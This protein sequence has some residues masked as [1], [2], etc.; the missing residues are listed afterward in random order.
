MKQ[1][2]CVANL[3]SRLIYWMWLTANHDLDFCQ[4]LSSLDVKSEEAAAVYDVSSSGKSSVMFSRSL[5]AHSVF[6]FS[7]LFSVSLLTCD[8]E[9]C[10]QSSRVHWQSTA[11]PVVLFSRNGERCYFLPASN[12]WDLPHERLLWL[13]FARENHKIQSCTHARRY[14]NCGIEL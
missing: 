8:T 10:G 4:N 9:I 3:D 11:T 12:Q 14:K 1:H 6:R 5:I 7:F 13:S 2:L